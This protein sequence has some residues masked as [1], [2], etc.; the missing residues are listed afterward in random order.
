M[1]TPVGTPLA[2]ALHGLADVPLLQDPHRLFTRPQDLHRLISRLQRWGS[3]FATFSQWAEAVTAGAG[4]GLATLTFDDGLADNLDLIP[5]LR[6]SGAAATVFVVT[7][8]LGGLH[9]EL[10]HRPIL[11]R[12][13][14]RR[15]HA[16]GIEIGSHTTA[17]HNLAALAYEATKR[18]LA[19]SRVRLE[20]ILQAPVTVAAYPYGATGPDTRRACRDAGFAAACIV[21]GDHHLDPFGLPRVP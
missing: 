17:H 4:H 14:V 18:D 15:L 5:L 11:T 16:A 9:P 13:D 10:P 3:R 21:G 6:A 19:Q 2:V 7:D 12:E 20:E 8:W 1:A